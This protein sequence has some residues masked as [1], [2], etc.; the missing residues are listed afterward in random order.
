MAPI[1]NPATIEQGVTRQV[2]TGHSARPDYAFRINCDDIAK[3]LTGNANATF[4]GTYG[5][6]VTVE[7]FVV[8]GIG[9]Q[10]LAGTAVQ[11]R[12]HPRCNGRICP[13]IGVY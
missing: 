2:C 8:V 10:T 4:I 11:R 12:R 13:R 1:E 5:I 3:L 7:G 6:G 9:P